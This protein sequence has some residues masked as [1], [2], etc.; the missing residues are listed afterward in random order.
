MQLGSQETPPTAGERTEPSQLSSKDTSS[1]D[2]TSDV[3]VPRTVNFDLFNMVVSY[4]RMAIFLEPVTDVVEVL[5]YLLGWVINQ[6]V[7]IEDRLVDVHIFDVR[8]CVCI[9]V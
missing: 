4:K 2:S 3:G 9:C 7:R 8:V 6:I 5:R 1:L